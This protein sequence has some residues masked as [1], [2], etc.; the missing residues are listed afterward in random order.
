MSLKENIYILIE[1]ESDVLSSSFQNDIL[2][3]GNVSLYIDN[4]LV[5]IN[6][7]NKEISKPINYYCLLLS[8]K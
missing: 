8:G 5:V 7:L 3:S 2:G 1:K 6:C 4:K